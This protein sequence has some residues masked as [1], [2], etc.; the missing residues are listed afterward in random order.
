MQKRAEFAEDGRAEAWKAL[1]EAQSQVQHVREYAKN[2]E[3]KLSETQETIRTIY[4]HL[5][6]KGN[7]FAE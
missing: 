5:K 3:Q 1:A 7:P 2:L 4:V 6:Q